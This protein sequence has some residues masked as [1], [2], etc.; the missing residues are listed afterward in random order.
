MAPLKPPEDKESRNK[1]QKAHNRNVG[2]RIKGI[3]GSLKRSFALYGLLPACRLASEGALSLG[4]AWDALGLSGM[5]IG[6]GEG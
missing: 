6:V 2:I 5:N 1:E 4:T 3:S